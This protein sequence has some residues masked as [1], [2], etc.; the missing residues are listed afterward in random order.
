MHQGGEAEGFYP[1]FL[2]FPNVHFHRWLWFA[3]SHP[4]Q[5]SLGRGR[6]AGLVEGRGREVSW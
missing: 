5:C 3:V 4:F 1:L 6:I 2:L